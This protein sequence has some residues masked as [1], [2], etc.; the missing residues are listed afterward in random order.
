[1]K[2]CKT[3]ERLKLPPDAPEGKQGQRVRGHY[4]GST[5]GSLPGAVSVHG[6]AARA[7]W[8]LFVEVLKQR[9]D[10]LPNW[11]GHQRPAEPRHGQGPAALRLTA[12]A[13]AKS[14]CLRTAPPLP[15]RENCGSVP[16]H[17]LG[18]GSGYVTSS[19]AA[20]ITPVSRASISASWS[21][22]RPELMRQLFCSH[23]LGSTRER[24]FGH[25][26]YD[27]KHILILSEVWQTAVNSVL[28]IHC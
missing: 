7:P 17:Y 24:H 18:R 8:A 9:P 11:T 12:A 10:R 20:L 5:W 25:I 16:L 23:Q 2:V 26:S 4:F 19:A 14:G 21:T 22:N 27:S 28:P 15:H 1:M 3:E 13:D 6:S